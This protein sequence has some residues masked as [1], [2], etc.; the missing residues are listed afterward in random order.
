MDNREKKKEVDLMEYWSVIVKRKWVLITFAGSL[1]FFVGIF[2]FLATPKYKS[3][4]TLLIEE[5]S[6]RILSIEEAFGYQSPVFRDLRFFNT[7]L[8]LL[9]SKKANL[10]QKE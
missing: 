2:S 8:E 4:A 3:T 7:Q 1:I 6:S 5:G 10:W 9:K